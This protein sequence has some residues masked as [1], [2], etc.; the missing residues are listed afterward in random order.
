MGQARSGKCPCPGL[1]SWTGGWPAHCTGLKDSQR[2]VID[3]RSP[4]PA[5]SLMSRRAS[6]KKHSSE[7]GFPVSV[8][9]RQSLS[10]SSEPQTSVPE[11][12]ISLLRCPHRPLP[13]P[14]AVGSDL[15]VMTEVCVGLL[16]RH[17][18]G[19]RGAGLSPLALPLPHAAVLFP[20]GPQFCLRRP[21]SVVGVSGV[22]V[23]NEG[24]Q[25][26]G[27]PRGLY[28]DLSFD[29][30][31]RSQPPSDQAEGKKLRWI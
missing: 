27:V 14:R 4:H 7:Q 11:S 12:L 26:N 6:T 18:L 17:I 9:T 29:D 8:L 22:T 2:A 19:L 13:L 16:E 20:R 21:D 1:G 25:E 15:T 3:H 24:T 5:L 28:V 30:C 31:T 10:G 23:G